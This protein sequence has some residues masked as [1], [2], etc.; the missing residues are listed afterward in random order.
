PFS[1]GSSNPRVRLAWRTSNPP[2]PSPRARAWTLTTTSSPSAT[3]PV[4]RGYATQGAPSTSRRTRPSNR[5]PTAVTRP[6]RRLRVTTRRVHE[7][8]RH[9]D[10]PVQVVDGDLLVGRVDV[11]HP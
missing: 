10:H 1:A 7:R 11:R 6:R 4:S 9:L 5:S 8:Q 3:G 2:E